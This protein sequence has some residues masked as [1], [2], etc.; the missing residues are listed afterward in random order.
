[1]IIS[2]SK[3]KKSNFKTI[4]G[5]LYECNPPY[6]VVVPL[7]FIKPKYQNYNIC[8]CIAWR[9]TKIKTKCFFST[10]ILFGL[11]TMIIAKQYHFIAK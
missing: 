1:M 5:A 8:I 7:R 6:G 4:G 9:I 10:G 2:I 3:T 11:Q